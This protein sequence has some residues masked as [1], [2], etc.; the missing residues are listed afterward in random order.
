MPQTI[1]KP[2]GIRYVYRLCAARLVILRMRV[3]RRR[4][5]T[6]LSGAVASGSTMIASAASGAV[7]VAGIAGSG[8]AGYS[9]GLSSTTIAPS[10]QSGPRVQA[11]FS[12]GREDPNNKSVVMPGSPASSARLPEVQTTTTVAPEPPA[13]TQNSAVSD[14][15]YSLGL[16]Q[17]HA[18][19]P[20]T[21]PIPLLL[22]SVQD[23]EADREA[24][25]N[26]HAQAMV[27]TQ[28][29]HMEQALD[30]MTTTIMQ[31]EQETLSLET[32]LLDQELAHAK[33]E[34]AWRSSAVEKRVVYNITN[35]PLG[36]Y[37]AGDA[38]SEGPTVW[39][40]EPEPSVQDPYQQDPYEQYRLS[41][42]D[43]ERWLGDQYLQDELQRA[44]TEAAIREALEL[45]NVQS[46][47]GQQRQ[48]FYGPAP[49]RYEDLVNPSLATTPHEARELAADGPQ[50]FDTVQ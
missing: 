15:R 20:A 37:V 45:G 42:E 35:V 34:Q 5:R 22:P 47:P 3:E 2:T 18:L 50:P 36:T 32:Q 44:E 33:A 23:M 16:S 31:L 8:L 21:P 43:G 39:R 6:A 41:T 40:D 4:Q 48:S 12:T 24:R 14:G 29:E 19:L 13:H 28:L 17:G 9:L 49:D 1:D 38:G 10:E 11:F 30:N 25:A 7:V 46:E 26:A 27:G